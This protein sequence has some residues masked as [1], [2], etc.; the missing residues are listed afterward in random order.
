MIG[1]PDD[2]DYL[3]V[4]Q[5]MVEIRRN[6]ITL[7]LNVSRSELVDSVARVRYGIHGMDDEHYGMAVAELLQAGCIPFVPDS[8]GQVEI[9]GV[10]PA[11]RY[12]NEEEAVRKIA[13][14]IGNPALQAQLLTHLEERRQLYSTAAFITGMRAA[15]ERFFDVGHPVTA[16]AGGAD[17]G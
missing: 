1:T 12:A 11:L 14:V 16:A 3:A 7:R 6:W 9:V 13:C 2:P 4:I 10:A 17:Q 15:A 5:R 8:G